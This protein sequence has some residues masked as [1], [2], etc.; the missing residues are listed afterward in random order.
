MDGPG[1]CAGRL[2][3]QRGEESFRVADSEW[4]K[5]SLGRICHILGCGN[6]IKDVKETFSPGSGDFFKWAVN[7]GA[8]AKDISDCIDPGTI[9][10]SGTSKPLMLACEGKHACNQLSTLH[11]F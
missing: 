6:D 4:I 9:T 5:S 3:I 10:S 8:E 2:E 11:C 1:R 7:C